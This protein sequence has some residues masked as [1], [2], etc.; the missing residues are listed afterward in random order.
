[1]LMS[2]LPLADSFPVM[3]IFLYSQLKSA[4]NEDFGERFSCGSSHPV[5]TKTGITKRTY[6]AIKIFRVIRH[7]P[8]HYMSC[9]FFNTLYK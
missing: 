3:F 7:L 1:M 9:E 4:I 8:I 6:N 5:M 2:F